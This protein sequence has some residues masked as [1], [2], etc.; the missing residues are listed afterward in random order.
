M[1]LIRA[2]FQSYLYVT[3]LVEDR[4]TS[5]RRLRQLLFGARTEKTDA[6][7]G[8]RTDGPEATMPGG[9]A[10]GTESAAGE[11]A[12]EASGAAVPGPA[13]PGHGRNG[14]DAYQ[15]AERVNVPHPAL[16]AGDACP[17][18]GQGTV[19]EKVPGVLVRV[20]GQPPLA[21]TVYQLQKLRC[22]LCGQVFT[23][24]AARR[25]GCAKYDATAGSMVALLK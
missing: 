20:T 3:D 24:P 11:A 9:A 13:R 7:M 14:A 22:H 12:T 15:G 19:Y 10:T 1:T 16:G 5:L 17:A 4:N 25:G 8:Q 23:A 21:A 18:C 2:V 6:V